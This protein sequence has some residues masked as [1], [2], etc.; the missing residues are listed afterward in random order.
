MSAFMNQ[1][2]LEINI[3]SLNVVR[4]NF[5]EFV[6]QPCAL[7]LSMMQTFA[8]HVIKILKAS[9]FES[10]FHFINTEDRMTVYQCVII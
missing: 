3:I 9:S 1:G 8:L 2:V 7:S 4:Q 10:T 5:M 6:K